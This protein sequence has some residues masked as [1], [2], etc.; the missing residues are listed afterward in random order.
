MASAPL[1]RQPDFLRFWLGESFS[2]IGTQVTSLAL[3]LTAISVAGGT[4]QQVGL[5]AVASTLTTLVLTPLAGPW[6]DARP[7]L[8]V[9]VMTNV[10]RALALL[11]VPVSYIWFSVTIP[12]LYAVAVVSGA[13]TAVFDIA[14]L[15]YIPR[16]VR[17]DEL[18][19]ANA[20]VSASI[21]VAETAGPAV[22]GLLIQLLTAPLTILADVG[23]YVVSTVLLRGITRRE[24]VPVPPPETGSLLANAWDGIRFCFT[25]RQIRP[26]L[27]ASAWFNMFEQLIMTVFLVY[28]VS[29]LALPAS[30]VGGLLTAAGLGATVGSVAATRLGRRFG[31]SIVM[32]ASLGT[33]ATALA[34]VP[35]PTGPVVLLMLSIAFFVYGCGIGVFNVH[36]VSYRQAV[37]PDGLQGRVNAGYRMFVFG[38]LPIGAGLAAWLGALLGPRVIIGCAAIALV[39][40][41]VLFGCFGLTRLPD[42]RPA[43]AA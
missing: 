30:V 8:P 33:A 20:K 27:L 23:S 22:G 1:R 18:V 28:A 37:V 26:L 24:R 6:L 9:I 40:G 34:V 41:T 38:A 36:A 5:L 35:V 39:A 11:A 13:L 3:P 43:P 31:P 2:W 4:T 42:H 10:L 29:S 15:T 21:S 25:D 14:V 19:E 12:L 16:L 17:Q 32:T 7:V